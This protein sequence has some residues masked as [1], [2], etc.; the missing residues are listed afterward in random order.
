MDVLTHSVPAIITIICVRN[1]NIDTPDAE[2][3]FFWFVLSNPLYIY[4]VSY[5][6]PN[7]GMASII[8]RVFYFA[9]GAVAPVAS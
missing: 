4:T 5:I 2:H 9:F 8:T 1:F 6:F 7:D 3:L